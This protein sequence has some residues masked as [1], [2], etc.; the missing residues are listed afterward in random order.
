MKVVILIFIVL[1]FGWQACSSKKNSPTYHQVN[2]TAPENYLYRISSEENYEM[3]VPCGYR[4]AQGEIVIPVGKYAVCWSDTI[5][6]FG[7]V[8]DKELT[9][10]QWTAISVSDKV[11]YEVHPMDNGPDY[12]SEGMFRIIRDGK[13]GFADREGFII[14]DPIYECAFPFKNGRAKV[15]LDCTAEKDLDGNTI[16]DSQEWTFIDRKY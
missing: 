11:L 14:V 4:N 1:S 10:G 16:V 5:K 2:T 6:N 13:I 12:I 7:I 8:S 15:A 3:G 9:D